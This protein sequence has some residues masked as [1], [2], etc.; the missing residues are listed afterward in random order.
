MN[1]HVTSTQT[2]RQEI[3]RCRTRGESELSIA[4][5]IL[6]CFETQGRRHQKSKNRDISGST[7]RTDVLRTFIKN[8]YMS[9][10]ICYFYNKFIWKFWKILI[11]EKRKYN[12]FLHTFRHFA[13]AIFLTL[14]K[15]MRNIFKLGIVRKAL[16][17]FEDRSYCNP[18]L[19]IIYCT[20]PYTVNIKKMARKPVA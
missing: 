4:C 9:S 7:T 19:K 10:N 1:Y 13:L 11:Q 15:V 14:L 5:G 17:I 20:V 6:P 2:G 18:K 12:V 3:S 8:Y 16:R